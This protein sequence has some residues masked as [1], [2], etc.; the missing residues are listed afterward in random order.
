MKIYLKAHDLW[1]V[2]K[3]GR[4][5]P[6]LRVNPTIAQMKHHSEKCIKRYKVMS[7]IQ[8]VVTYTI[9]T[10]IMAC[11]TAKEACDKLKEEFQDQKNASNKSEKGV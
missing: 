4:E 8:S 5:P 1:E 7:C 2:V 3:T 6:Q 9:F 11:E 10:R